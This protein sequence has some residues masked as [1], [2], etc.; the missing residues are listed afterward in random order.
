MQHMQNTC[1]TCNEGG[2]DKRRARETPG[3]PLCAH[4]EPYTTG[5]VIFQAFPR[6]AE[7]CIIVTIIYFV[8]PEIITKSVCSSRCTVTFIMLS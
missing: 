2:D 5:L 3:V 1:K 6:T 4:Q 8:I 7:A